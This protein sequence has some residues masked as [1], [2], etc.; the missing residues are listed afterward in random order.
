MDLK[1]V[2]TLGDFERILSSEVK[3][4]RFW[5]NLDLSVEDYQN[6]RNTLSARLKTDSLKTILKLYPVSLITS[7][8]FFVRYKY[9]TN[10][11]ELWAGELGIEITLYDQKNIG[12][13]ILDTF[14]K[15]GFNWDPV[16]NEKRIYIEPII[17]QACLPPE[18]CLDD[19]FFAIKN[20]N[21]SFFDPQMFLEELIN[22]KAYTIRKPMRLFL[23]NFQDT[24]AIEYVLN[25][26]D[27]M[28]AVEQRGTVETRYEIQYNEW[29]EKERSERSNS[30]GKKGQE[31]HQIKPYLKFEEGRN[32]LCIV[33]PWTILSREWIE[34]ARWTVSGS[35]GKSTGVTC[36]VF[37]DDGR[38]YIESISIPICP[39][40][41]Y[42]ISL[43][44]A[45]NDS[46]TDLYTWKIDGVT[47]FLLFNTRGTAVSSGYL[48][49]PFSSLVMKNSVII[50]DSRDITLI[51]QDYPTRTEDYRMINLMVTAPNAY[52]R[53]KTPS[54][55][56]TLSARPNID[57]S[58][59]GDTLFDIPENETNLF[60]RIPSLKLDLTELAF[61][62]NLEIRIGSKQIPLE[63]E[64]KEEIFLIDLNKYYES[65][66]LKYGTYSIRLYQNGRFLKQKEFSFVPTVATDYVYYL[67]WP[68]KKSQKRQFHFDF[69]KDWELNFE[70]CRVERNQNS[71]AVTIPEDLDVIRGTI[72]STSDSLTFKERFELPLVPLSLTFIDPKEAAPETIY[73]SPV[74]IGLDDF[75]EQDKWLA[76]T[77]Y[78]DFYTDKNY[79]IALI[80]N[81]GLEQKT[82][83]HI[84]SRRE[85]I[86]SLTVFRDTI[87]NSVLPA[88]LEVRCAEFPEQCI[89][90][91][92]ISD[93]SGM[94]DYPVYLPKETGI[95]VLKTDGDRKIAF[96]R[97]GKVSVPYTIEENE[98]EDYRG[99]CLHRF[100]QQLPEGI[101]TFTDNETLFDLFDFKEDS[102]ADLKMEN[103][104][105]L[106]S[107]DNFKSYLPDSVHWFLQ[108]LV[109]LLFR[110]KNDQDLVTDEKVCR[111]LNRETKLFLMKN[112]D[113]FEI[114]LLVALGYLLNSK[115]SKVRSKFITACMK[116]VSEEILTGLDRTR[117]I[118]FLT[119]LKCPFSVFSFCNSAYSLFLFDPDS[120]D[121]KS[122]AEDVEP[123]SI[124]LSYLMLIDT[125]APL[126][127]TL[128]LEKYRTLVGP[129]ALADI[130]GINANNDIASAKIDLKKFLNDKKTENIHVRLTPDISGEMKPLEEMIIEKKNKYIFDLD[131]KPEIGIYFA[132]IRFCDQ[133]VNW[134]RLNH[135][136]EGIIFPVTKTRML[137][138]INEQTMA[139]IE[140]TISKLRRDHRWKNIFNEYFEVLRYRCSNPYISLKINSLPRYFY[141]QGLAAFFS[142]IP[143]FDEDALFIRETG[144]QFLA[145]AY[146]ISPRMVRRDIL[147]ASTFIYLKKKEA[148][149]C[150]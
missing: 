147:M 143:G 85:G 74:I 30:K 26:R 133:Y 127:D 48:P 132:Q 88:V 62:Q 63:S 32:G 76:V 23:E 78:G 116:I 75:L 36:R 111:I 25:I 113:D 98:W 47:D 71:Y 58:I 64:N 94:R 138:V 5:G 135:S 96:T 4:V 50:E 20:S 67:K 126:Q 89:P 122:L 84:S 110:K 139:R 12:T 148:E 129:E 34:E 130:L 141:L 15:Y 73:R 40:A 3:G 87:R 124:E 8:V 46:D 7:A 104:S 43:R 54:K 21:R 29:N 119:E 60:I 91:L 109:N 81:D 28:L 131:R 114:E 123:Y 69:V 106:I 44:D 137:N 99:Y 16:K 1:D 121:M 149:L 14:R 82:V 142:R 66:E 18:S 55:I 97:F 93:K 35:D 115:I 24:D 22:E 38:R 118:R 19:L 145:T 70:D 65:G 120:S 77:A 86:V 41:E 49:A 108:Y 42:V 101:Y 56:I 61:R 51:D 128:R 100:H 31:K 72:Q 107:T 9:N 11:W 6:L 57:I 92:V 103:P 68:G 2:N 10:F 117:I 83:L 37:G 90:F 95:A 59:N 39:A 112:L 17:Y 80:T 79:S 102:A 27:A 125:Y 134:Y 52:L 105:F 150:Q 45:E 146:E 140:E 33:L 53:I 144:N 13:G 136:Y